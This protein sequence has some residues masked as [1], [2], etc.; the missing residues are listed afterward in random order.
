M[1]SQNAPFAIRLLRWFCHPDLIEDVEGDLNELFEEKLGIHS[2][3]KE[4]WLLWMDV[5]KLFRLGIMRPFE[6]NYQLNRYGMS[7]NY[8]KISMRSMARNRLF[9]SINV[10]AC[11]QYVCGFVDD[12]VYFEFTVL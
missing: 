12:C 10:R 1:N 5:L 9:T 7:K 11:C 6:G 2:S 4:K 3:I 8:F